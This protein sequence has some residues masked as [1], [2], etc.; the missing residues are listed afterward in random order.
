[1]TQSTKCIYGSKSRFLWNK[2]NGG[3]AS[4]GAE[5]AG[6]KAVPFRTSGGIAGRKCQAKIK[7]EAD[8]FGFS[9][10]FRGC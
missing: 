6:G 8:R 4:I 3:G 2:Q 10:G 9:F 7:R 1:M 5:S